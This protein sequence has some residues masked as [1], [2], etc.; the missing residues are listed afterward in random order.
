MASHDKLRPFK[1]VSR[2]AQLAERSAQNHEDYYSRWIYLFLKNMLP[3]YKRRDVIKRPASTIRVL[4]AT[5]LQGGG[6]GVAPLPIEELGPSFYSPPY[7]LY[8]KA[9]ILHPRVMSLRPNEV[10]TLET[11]NGNGDCHGKRLAS[12][13]WEK[14]VMMGDFCPNE[15]QRGLMLSKTVDLKTQKTECG[16][17][18]AKKSSEQ[19]TTEHTLSC[20]RSVGG[21]QEEWGGGHKFKSQSLKKASGY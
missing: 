10:S 8:N 13:A 16:D 11:G 12:P 19:C 2:V 17:Y 6:Q 14:P 21:G 18:C 1:E 3:I 5:H 9:T 7:K 15:M 20:G 4:T